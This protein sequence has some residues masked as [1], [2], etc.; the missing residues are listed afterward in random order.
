M[1]PPQKF[2]LEL[3]RIYYKSGYK[4]QL[5]RTYEVMLPFGPEK[6]IYT[7]WIDFGSSGRFVV[8]T[9]YAWDGPSGPTIDSKTNMRGSLEHDALFQLMRRGRL[10]QSF[11]EKANDRLIRVFDK[12]GMW[13]VRQEWYRIGVAIGAGKYATPSQIREE[14]TAPY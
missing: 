11:L 5:T 10:P 9:G 12:D 1:K 13:K 4:Y 14:H 2:E 7:D 3:P 6:D 8:R